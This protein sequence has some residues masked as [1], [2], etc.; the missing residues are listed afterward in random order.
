[1]NI[2]FGIKSDDFETS[3]N[4]PKFRNDTSKSSYYSLFKLNIFKSN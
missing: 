3:L 4:I 1:M 2:F